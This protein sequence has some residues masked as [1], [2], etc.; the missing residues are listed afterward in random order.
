MVQP[1]ALPKKLPVGC[2][3]ARDLR[4]PTVREG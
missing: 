2:V 4:A 3:F 1:I